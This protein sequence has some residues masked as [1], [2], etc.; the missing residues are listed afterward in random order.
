MQ[1]HIG[2]LILAGHFRTGDGPGELDLEALL[3]QLPEES[4]L[5]KPLPFDSTRPDESKAELA[6]G[7]LLGRLQDVR[8]SLAQFESSSDQDSE[9]TRSIGSLGLDTWS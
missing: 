7:Q 2:M 8:N 1:Q 3:L 6:R 9:G 4:P 5:T